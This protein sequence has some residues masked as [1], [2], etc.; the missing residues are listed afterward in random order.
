MNPQQQ[1]FDAAIV[2][3]PASAHPDA[4]PAA[5][6]ARPA[7]GASAPV[8][9]QATPPPS[10]LA[11]DPPRELWVAVQSDAWQ[12][13]PD[14]QPGS[15]PAALAALV[16]QAQR[17]TPRVT[18]ESSDALLLE[19]AGSLRLFGGLKPLLQAL[20]EAFPRPLRL[21]L[22]PTPLAAVLLARAGCNCCIL[23]LARLKG[24]LASL[25]LAHLRWPGEDLA[26]LNSMG[27]RTL[28]E[29]LRLPRAGLARRIGPE[30]LWQ[31]DRLTGARAD[32]RAALAQPENFHE[33]VDPDH[34][35]LDR[36][37]LLAALQ[38]ALERLEIFLR[39][40]QRGV[41]AL[42]LRL[43]YRR[44]AP[45]ACLVRCVVPEYRAARFTALLAARLEALQLAEPVRRMELIAGRPRRFVAAS[46]PL[47]AAGEHG[48][49]PAAAQAPEFLQT[50]LARLGDEAVYS[51]A[52][53]D[54][55]RPERRQRRVWPA[56]S[57]ADAA[58]RG[59]AAPDAL[60]APE[61]AARPLGLLGQPQPL[62]MLRDA[63]GRAYALRHAGLD[64]TLLSGPERIQTGWWDDGAIARDYYVA[65]A[66]DGARWWI[67]RECDPPRR[68]FVHGGF[69]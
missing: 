48:G 25:P 39:E 43:H 38:P 7:P 33:R 4:A 35:T 69:A 40:R 27:V 37:R 23:S 1:L 42:R 67:F 59:R 8:A 20:R 66:S 16:Q 21:A 13:A 29:L 61:G 36:E 60:P 3:H 55:H 62:Q 49:Q 41:M 52:E 47:W 26:R 68:W 34:E 51:L 6:A 28:A 17:F 2:P 5:P 18:V 14:A 45:L 31:L 54:E 30:R 56:I 44:A 24:R 65:R 9:L 46:T 50:L 19:L 15:L 57:E 11:P 64:L 12:V 58:R 10:A 53:I 63:S 32:P 22:A